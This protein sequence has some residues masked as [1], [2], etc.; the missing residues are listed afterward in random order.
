M[1]W[2][3]YH[4]LLHQDRKDDYHTDIYGFDGGPS[5]SLV[6]PEKGAVFGYVQSGIL[7]I[8]DESVDGYYPRTV[9]A[10]RY[11]CTRNGASLTALVTGTK[12][13]LIQRLGFVNIPMI[14]GPIED[15]GRLRYIDGCSDT[16]LISPSRK[17]D[18]CLNF[19]HFP[20][21]IDQTEHT[22]PSLRV[23]MVAKGSGYCTTPFGRFRLIPGLLFIIPKDGL[24]KFDTVEDDFMDVIAYHPDSDFGPENETH[25]MIN[26]TLVGGQKI[27]NTQGSHVH[28]K[29]MQ[30]DFDYT[31]SSSRP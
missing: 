25:P 31:D 1:A 9:L 15:L 27:D 19:L 18:A 13:V 24:H 8:I 23:G 10:G 21:K 3:S 17:G 20:A 29:V 11:F 14:G 16:L 5:D 30:V 7:R 26:R 6:I 12:A 4:G 2:D 22:H 28:A